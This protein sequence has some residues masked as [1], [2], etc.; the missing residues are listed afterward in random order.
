MPADIIV[1]SIV[2]VLVYLALR[3]LRKRGDGCGCSGGC[4]SCGS[5]PAH[6][7]GETHKASEAHGASETR[8][9]CGSHE[10][11]CHSHSK[12][13]DANVASKDDQT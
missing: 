10:C 4:G 13:P 3:R 9:A 12:S 7:D 1:G 11:C 2:A 6:S 5:C 8:G